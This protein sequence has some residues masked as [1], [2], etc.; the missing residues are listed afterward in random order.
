MVAK[1]DAEAAAG[2][3]VNAIEHYRNA[4][5]HALQL[6]LQ[7]DLNPDG[8]TR[9]QF[10]GNHSKSY[11]IEASTDMVN[12]AP[13]APAVP[14]PRAT[15]NSLI[16]TWRLSLCVLPGRRAVVW[17][18]I[19]LG[20]GGVRSLAAM[21]LALSWTMADDTCQRSFTAGGEPPGH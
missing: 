3:Y 4:W 8:S 17:N 13:L 15:F 7:V 11:L 2:R 19:D 9:V 21:H 1:G 20:P 5:R 16:Q 10:I 6:R 12:W 14:M 18:S